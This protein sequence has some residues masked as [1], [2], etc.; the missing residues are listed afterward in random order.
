M[1]AHELVADLTKSCRIRQLSAPVFVFACAL[2]TVGHQPAN[3]S[4]SIPPLITDACETESLAVTQRHAGC[5]PSSSNY[6][7]GISQN[8]KLQVVVGERQLNECMARRVIYDRPCAG[9]WLDPRHES[10]KAASTSDEVPQRDYFNTVQRTW[11]IVLLHCTFAVVRLR[12]DQNHGVFCAAVSHHQGH[13]IVC[14]WRRRLRYANAQDVRY[15][16]SNDS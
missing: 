3:S 6:P 5:H 9:E 8:G 10:S 7:S 4:P 12:L 13:S 11:G 1:L 15:L 16:I 2:P 14:H